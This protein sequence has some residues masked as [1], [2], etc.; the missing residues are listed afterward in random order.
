MAGAVITAAIYGDDVGKTAIYASIGA[1]VG[2]AVG[3]VTSQI[4]M[5]EW[6]G[7]LVAT[8]TGALVGGAT[9][10]AMG[11]E[12]SD[13]AVNG[14]ISAAISSASGVIVSRIARWTAQTRGASPSSEEALSVDQFG[15]RRMTD[16][17][18][19]TYKKFFPNLNPDEVRILAERDATYNCFAWC[20]GNTQENIPPRP[21][22]WTAR[23]FEDYF[24]AKGYRRV[25]K[26]EGEIAMY[27]GKLSVPGYPSGP[28]HAAKHLAG[29]WWTSKIGEE[30]LIVHKLDH[31]EGESYGIVTG[32]YGK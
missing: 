27:Y 1:V 6:A 14:A 11:G 20:D 2:F 15:G 13:G 7:V 19:E 24:G 12:F 30:H 22:A 21:S 25:P 32:F 5:P 17:E 29:V 10:E 18:V 3:G 26:S 16:R 8:G 4:P 28:T 31:L 9:A 23:D